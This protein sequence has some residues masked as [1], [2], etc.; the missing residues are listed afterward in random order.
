MPSGRGRLFLV[1][2]CLIVVICSLLLISCKPGSG[3]SLQKKVTG[4]W[5]IVYP[6][7][8]TST[9][10]ERR[11]YARIQDS[12]LEG[13]ALK[14]VS[15]LENG[16]FIQWDSLSHAGSWGITEEK[17]VVVGNGGK[18]F[19]NF[20]AE[21]MREGDEAILREKVE[22]SDGILYIKWHLSRLNGG[23]SAELTN[24]E[25]NAWR[26]RPAGPETEAAMRKRMAAAL[27][28]YSVYF[29][30]VGD[31]ANFFLPYRVMLP[32]RFYQHA[33]GM[34]DQDPKHRFY[35]LFYSEEDAAKGYAMLKT[36]INDSDLNYPDVESDSY[37][38]EYAMMLE[39]LSKEL[40]KE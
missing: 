8:E 34:R 30:L 3:G 39:E 36:L 35:S 1:M 17:Q 21:F 12:L 23:A 15:F 19:K 33:I 22:T 24:P 40:Q 7:E 6:E 10:A 2:R 29:A 25:K 11:L 5:F 32:F 18:G 37:S 27:H 28:Y 4:N 16:T 26:K 9:E 20:R 14:P 13:K 31:A 38:K